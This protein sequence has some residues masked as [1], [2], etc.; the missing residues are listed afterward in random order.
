[1]SLDPGQSAKC[2]KDLTGIV[3]NSRQV[4]AGH[5]GIYWKRYLKPTRTSFDVASKVRVAFDPAIPIVV[6]P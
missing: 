3:P 4:F 5:G 2:R 6:L 1:M